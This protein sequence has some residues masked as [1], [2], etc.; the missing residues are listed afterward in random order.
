M[1]VLIKDNLNIKLRVEHLFKNNLSGYF[2]IIDQTLID[3]NG[4]KLSI[5]EISKTNQIIKGFKREKDALL[6]CGKIFNSFN[7][8]EELFEIKNL[9]SD[10]NIKSKNKLIDDYKFELNYNNSLKELKIYLNQNS[11]PTRIRDDFW[12]DYASLKVRLPYFDYDNIRET[13]FFPDLEEPY[14]LSIATATG[15]NDSKEVEITICPK[16]MYLNNLL[17]QSSFKMLSDKI[18]KL[19]N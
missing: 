5:N 7:L 15:K 9:S 2:I 1:N 12:S 6:Y 10:E 3:C 19:A 17:P 18:K 14:T 13:D 8:E 4:N 16:A 11:I